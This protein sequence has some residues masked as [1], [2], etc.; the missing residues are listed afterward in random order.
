MDIQEYTSIITHMLQQTPDDFEWSDI[1]Y[2]AKANKHKKTHITLTK[3]IKD[4]LNHEKIEGNTMS[5]LMSAMSKLNLQ[6]Y[7]SLF[8]TN[9]KLSQGTFQETHLLKKQIL[10]KYLY[11][12]TLS[13]TKFLNKKCHFIPVF[14]GP[15]DKGHWKL[16]VIKTNKIQKNKSTLHT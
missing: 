2:K 1:N 16:A 11:K 15:P 5:A 12:N 8:Y 4:A 10:T 6:T 3:H 7:N 13:K 9:I 14:S